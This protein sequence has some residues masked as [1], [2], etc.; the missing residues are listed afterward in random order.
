MKKNLS[1]IIPRYK[2]TTKILVGLLSS[3]RSQSNLDFE[4]T[5]IIIVNDNTEDKLSTEW[6]TSVNKLFGLD[7]SVYDMEENGG[8][9]LARQFGLEK[10]KGKYVMFCD[11]DDTLYATDSVSRLMGE[12][13]QFPDTDYISSEWLEEQYFDN[14][15]SVLYVP[16]QVEN[17]WMHGKVFNRKFLM[18]N[19]IKFHPSLRVHE[20]SYFLLCASSVAKN[21]RHLLAQTYIWRSARNDSITR[22]NNNSYTYDSFPEF[23]HAICLGM[24]WLE[25]NDIELI[26]YTVVQLIMYCF[27]TLQQK[28]WLKDEH[29]EDRERSIAVLK[30]EITPFFEHYKN[31]SREFIDQVYNQEREKSFQNEVESYTL[32][33]WIQMIS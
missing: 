16:H 13:L 6:V 22:E 8:P 24:Q 9:G 15:Q 7:I 31:A 19:N 2:E 29:K 23:I 18:N 3:I 28:N 33:D 5:E 10:A 12:L 4:T 14:H 27:F 32:S 11:A 30:N 17:T 20:D 1:I 21:R 26:D 25:D